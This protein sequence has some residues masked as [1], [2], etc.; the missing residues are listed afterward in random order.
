MLSAR[1]YL[2]LLPNTLAKLA[3]VRPEP[4]HVA[5]EEGQQLE[6]PTPEPAKPPHPLLTAGKTL[7]LY[8]GGTALGYGGLMGA[9]AIRNVV[10]ARKGLPPTEL[11]QPDSVIT[12]AVPA[13]VGIGTVA[14]DHAQNTLFDRMR[15][16]E[17][18]RRELSGG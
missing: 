17:A 14:F 6:Q 9:R 10:R 5:G 15:A 4:S 12:H 1:F 11:F 8:A 16:D 3:D 2:E 18:K 7:G 13:L